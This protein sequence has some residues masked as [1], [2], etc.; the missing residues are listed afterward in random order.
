MID[1]RRGSALVW[2][3]VAGP[4]SAQVAT[5]VPGETVCEGSI[6]AQTLKVA[7][8]AYFAADWRKLQNSL[9]GIIAQAVR[10]ENGCPVQDASNGENVYFV[11]F[12]TSRSIIVRVPVYEDIREDFTKIV[13]GV[14]GTGGRQLY[15]VDIVL[16]EEDSIESTYTVERVRSGLADDLSSLLEML[17]P[18]AATAVEMRGH[19]RED[20]AVRVRSIP[21]PFDRS[22]VSVQDIYLSMTDSAGIAR[23][24]P[25]KSTWINLPLT[26]WSVSLMT[27]VMVEQNGD[28]PAKLDGGK[29]SRDEL[30]PGLALGG[31]HFYPLGYRTPEIA[32]WHERLSLFAAA[33]IAP[34]PGVALGLGIPIPRLPRL[35]LGLGHTWMLIDTIG[36]GDDFGG[37]PSNAEE[38]F[39]AGTR[40]AWFVSLVLPI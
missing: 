6:Q 27:G 20:R 32:R 8:D 5:V 35:M 3:L 29:L 12:R 37:V 30:S 2:F 38:P 10:V 11:V 21:I 13:P 25:T 1:P 34:R 36:N 15:Q 24:S 16:Q 28:A 23:G 7:D 26:H 31:L 40:R 18:V 22:T 14:S 17:V 19:A 4:A 9:R 39:S 33:T